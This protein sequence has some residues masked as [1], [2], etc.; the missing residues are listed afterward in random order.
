MHLQKIV[1]QVKLSQ[2]LQR[3]LF[4]NLWEVTIRMSQ[5]LIWLYWS[6]SARVEFS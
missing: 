3:A 5:L 6:I 1:T 4:Q 2:Q